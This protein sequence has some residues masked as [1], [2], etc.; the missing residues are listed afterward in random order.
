MVT[1]AAIHIYNLPTRPLN[2]LNNP[3]TE[4]EVVIVIRSEASCI[5]TTILAMLELD[6]KVFQSTSLCYRVLVSQY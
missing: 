5:D 4:D 1:A 3:P 6:A 2:C